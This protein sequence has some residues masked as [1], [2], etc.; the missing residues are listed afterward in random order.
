[1][2]RRPRSGVRNIRA[3]GNDGGG[4]QDLLHGIYG[5]VPDCLATDPE[6]AGVEPALL[7][8]LAYLP[9]LTLSPSRTAPGGRALFSPRR[10]PFSTI[11][12]C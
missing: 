11:E 5:D 6:T 7:P 2:P 4:R 9:K 3:T 12:W 10:E 8:I 1:M